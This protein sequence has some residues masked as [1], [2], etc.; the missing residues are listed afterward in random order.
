MRTTWFRLPCHLLAVATLLVGA[1]WAAQDKPLGKWLEEPRTFDGREDYLQLGDFGELEAATVAFWF[2]SSPLAATEQWQGLVT[3]DAWE[4]GVIHVPLRNRMIDVHLHMGDGRRARLTSSRLKSDSWYHVAVVGDTAQRLLRLYI[5]GYEQN[6]ADISALS[7]GLKLIRQVAGREHD[8]KQHGRYFKGAIREVRIYD[9]PLEAKEIRS[10]CPQAPRPADRDSRNI[11]TGLVI[12]D[13]G[14]CDQPYVVITQDGNWLCL[15]TTAGGHEGAADSH[16]VATISADEGRTWSKPVSLE[17][18]DGPES[19]YSL[20]VVARTGRV[21]AFYVYNGERF[22]CPGRSDC[23][24]WYVYKYSDDNGRSWSK[25]RYRLPMRMTAVDRA[26]TFKGR[27]QIFWGIGKPITLGDS[28]IFAFSK[29]GKYLIDRSEGWFYRSD[30]ILTQPDVNRIT[31]QLLPDGDLGLK[32]PKFGE[33]QAEQNIVPMGD[34]S[35]YCMY[36]TVTGYPCDAYSRDRGHTW[37]MPQHAAYTPGGKRMKNPRAC[38]RIWRTGNGRY[39]FWFHN[40]SGKTYEGRN[41]AW[42][43]GG[44]E[45]DGKI[46][47][48]QPEILLYDPLPDTRMSYPDLIEQ[49]GHYWITETN[50]TIARVHQVD[51]SLLEGLW[52]Q[53]TRSSVAREGLALQAGHRQLLD[54]QI[55]MPAGLDLEEQSGLSLDFWIELATLSEGQTILDGRDAAGRGILLRTGPQAT[56]RI[57]LGDGRSQASWDSDPGLLAEGRLHHVAIIVD[58]GPQIITFVVD[59]TLCDGGDARQYGWGRYDAP[60]GV[61]SHSG[62]LRIGPGL[63]GKLKKLRIYNRYLRTSEAVGNYRAGP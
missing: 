29:C 24:G 14:Y 16:V 20:P 31:W 32:N 23:V 53:G 5:N 42:I 15:P 46:C 18:A 63:K 33:V 57:E 30:N 8:G 22:R 27:V 40:H 51:K 41:P 28:M 7:T 25:E 1:A 36:R 60:L 9:R 56:I 62:K 3:S 11:R 39:L 52:Q 21:Y 19:V 4:E 17:P 34:G 13:E 12:P 35:I 49:H 58:S 38:P 55:D 61:V 50:K 37:T 2:K 43:S 10:L 47:W 59:G 6:V 54:G 26:N 44:L 45:R 48:S